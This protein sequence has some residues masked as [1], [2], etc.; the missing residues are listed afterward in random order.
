V[1]DLYKHSSQYL[2]NNENIYSTYSAHPHY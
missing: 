1:V 2:I